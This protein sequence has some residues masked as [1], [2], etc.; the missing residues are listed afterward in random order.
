MSARCLVASLLL[1]SLTGCAGQTINEALRRRTPRKGSATLAAGARALLQPP[2]IEAYAIGPLDVLEVEIV[3][4]RGVG[5]VTVHQA[6][7][8]PA[9][10]IAVPLVGRVACEGLTAEQ[11]R[12]KVTEALAARFIADPQVAVKV[13]QYRSKRVAVLGPVSRPGVVFLQQNQSTV[14]EVLALAGGLTDASGRVAMLVRKQVGPSLRPS[15]QIDLEQLTDGDLSQNHTI[16][17]GDVIQVLPAERYYVTGFVTTPG[18]YTMRKRT[19]LLEAI[20]IAGGVVDPDA[21]PDETYILRAGEPPIQCDLE[22]IASGE[23]EDPLLVDGDL[24]QVRQTLLREIGLGFY[25][26][27]R[28][29]IGFG[30]NL[31]SLIPPF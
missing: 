1:V 27:I 28:G 19:S 4:L 13:A 5:D 7:V 6:E 26:F 3:D 17:P 30:Y 14:V 16:H 31:A 11:V 2:R 22:A 29:G 21:S 20:S 18:E 24:V 15:L 8:D 25:R 10:Q 9:G 12:V 23:A